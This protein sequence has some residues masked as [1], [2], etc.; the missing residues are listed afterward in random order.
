MVDQIFDVFGRSQHLTPFLS[1]LMFELFMLDYR[2]SFNPTR[3]RGTST[4]QGKRFGTW[5]RLAPLTC[6]GVSIF[7]F[8]F[9]REVIPRLRESR[10]Q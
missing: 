8:T 7:G 3:Y 2:T 5:G 1:G 9:S 4:K 10:L 6:G